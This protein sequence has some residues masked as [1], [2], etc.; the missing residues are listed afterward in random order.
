MTESNIH[1]LPVAPNGDMMRDFILRLFEHAGMTGLV[2]VSWTST[3]A[4]HKLSGAR[5]FDLADLDLAAEEA[6]KLNASPSR[7]VYVSAGLRKPET[8][9]QERAKDDDVFACVAF[10]CDFDE[11]RALEQGLQEAIN[12]N[13]PPHLVVHTGHEP[14]TRGQ[15]WW[16]LDE[17]CTDL[18]LHNRLIRALTVQLK[19]DRAVT[20]PSRVMRIAGSVA[21]PLKAGRVLEMTSLAENNTERNKP[22]ELSYFEWRLDQCGATQQDLLQPQMPVST[23]QQ[24]QALDFNGASAQVDLDA[25]IT[26]ARKPGQWHNAALTATA[27]LI[28]R[29][30]PPDVALDMLTPMLQQPGFTYQRTRQELKVMIEGAFKRGFAPAPQAQ[31]S[32]AP[33]LLAEQSPFMSISQ[34][35][36][37]PPVEWIIEGYLQKI[38]MSAL[39]APPGAFKSFVA[40]D[41]ALSVAYGVPWHGFATQQRK[42]LYVVAEGLHGFGAR[43]LAWQQHRVNGADT[44]QFHVLPVP[45]NFMDPANVDLLIEKIQQYL[46]GVGLVVIDTVARNFGPGDENSTKDMNAYVAGSTR[47]MACGCHVMHVHHSG[48]DETK[49]ERGSSAFRA[50]LETALKLDREPGSDVVTLITRKQKNG[51]ELKPI[52][53][54]VVTAEAAHPDTGEILTSRVPTAQ[55]AV[56]NP[57]SA[58]TDDQLARLSKTQ[59]EIL[60]LV[61]SGTGSVTVLAMDAGV[62]KSNARRTLMRLADRKLVKQRND[63]FWVPFEQTDHTGPQ[64]NVQQNQED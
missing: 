27:H 29:G 35:I 52:R 61:R 21:W 32:I 54:A 7:N 58:P 42:V 8:P 2:E 25:L 55:E 11:P 51:P 23:V 45:V 24:T 41:M 18:A 64:E 43:A 44:D 31:P 28:A 10:W 22:Y 13:L 26:Q 49:D 46:N 62:D 19:G 12:I 30:T 20:N 15:L 53:L 14:H 38:A 1:P 56:E 63:G 16:I 36:N 48:K 3:R 17:P 6:A 39:F 47:L 33:E 34:L 5:L 40:L 4:P 50:A 57:P 59:R 37:M 60:K 9:T